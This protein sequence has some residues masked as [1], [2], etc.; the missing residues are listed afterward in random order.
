[1]DYRFGDVTVAC[2]NVDRVVSR[3]SGSPRA[4]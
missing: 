2:T 1:M 4:R 3:T